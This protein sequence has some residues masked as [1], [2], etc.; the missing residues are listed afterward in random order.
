[1]Y[2]EDGKSNIKNLGFD[3]VN[4]AVP[5]YGALWPRNGCATI[6]R[7]ARTA[8]RIAAAPMARIAA[9]VKLRDG[10]KQARSQPI[11]RAGDS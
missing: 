10:Q 4:F 8:V 5:Q 1:M 3:H 2:V 9:P 11:Q 7:H 6:S